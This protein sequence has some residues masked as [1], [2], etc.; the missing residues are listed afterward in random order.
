M[1]RGR[2]WGPQGELRV[3]PDADRH[4]VVRHLSRHDL[5]AIH[6]HAMMKAIGREFGI[7]APAGFDTAPSTINYETATKD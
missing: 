1:P 6:H 4:A 7:E 5:H 3:D 2:P